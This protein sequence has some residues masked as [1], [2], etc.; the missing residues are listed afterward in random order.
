MVTL[1]SRPKCCIYTVI[2]FV[3]AD[4]FLYQKLDRKSKMGREFWRRSIGRS[5]VIGSLVIGGSEEDFTDVLQFG[6]Q[7]VDVSGVGVDE[8]RVHT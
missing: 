8:N 1:I 6:W 7:P 3:L 5:L 2:T 4:V